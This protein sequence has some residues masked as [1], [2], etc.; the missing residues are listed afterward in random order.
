MKSGA[1]A[2]DGR[3]VAVPAGNG[4][5]GNA[6]PVVTVGFGASN[7]AA[8]DK[9]TSDGGK[10]GPRGNGVGSAPVAAAN[11]GSGANPGAPKSSFGG[12]TIIGGA[13]GTGSTAN[14][15]A[16]S[17]SAPPPRPLQ[18]SYGYTV[19]ST[20]SSGGG[21]PFVGVFSQEQVYT[22]F[23]DMRQ[24]ETDP[25]P[26]WT[27]QFSVLQETGAQAI[28]KSPTGTQQGL[29]LPFPAVKEQPA[30][31]A[32]L[33][34][35]YLRKMVIVYAIVNIEGKMEQMSVKDSPDPLLNESVLNAL[36]NWVFRPA[37]LNGEPVRAK[38]LLG[39]PLWL[40]N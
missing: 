33:V 39:I 38:I 32:E 18:T 21:I 37:R 35:K 9:K 11:S 3:P 24:T 8:K 25:A 34:H 6:A 19:I 12:I 40:P 28:A 13:G 22:V 23:L 31:P 29:V 15:G 30:L 4:G 7:D 26:S 10:D 17:A 1:T 14:S 36:R 2:E 16:N 27:L 5:A 20:E